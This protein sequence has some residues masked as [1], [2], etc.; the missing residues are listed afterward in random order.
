MVATSFT[1]YYRRA[2]GLSNRFQCT[3]EVNSS[4]LIITL[5]ALQIIVFFTYAVCMFYLRMTFQASTDSLALFKSKIIAGYVSPPQE[6]FQNN[7]EFTRIEENQRNTFR[8]S[9]QP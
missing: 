4:L 7:N 9:K 8:L 2:E 5:T 1:K 6:Y 3:Q